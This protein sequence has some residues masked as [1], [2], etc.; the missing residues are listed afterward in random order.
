MKLLT[1]KYKYATKYAT[2][3]LLGVLCAYS[4]CA[5]DNIQR[6]NPN[7][8]QPD[9]E[10]PDSSQYEPNPTDTDQDKQDNQEHQGTPDNQWEQPDE[11]HNENP[12]NQWEQPDQDHNE[13]PNDQDNQWEQPDE[14]HQ[15][16][17]DEQNDEGKCDPGYVWV[18]YNID[19]WLSTSIEYGINDGK[20]YNNQ[21]APC[22]SVNWAI[23]YMY[24][25]NY[26]CPGG[27]ISD[28]KHKS[29]QRQVEKCPDYTY[30]NSDLS[31]C[32]CTYGVPP[33][34]KTCADLVN[35]TKKPLIISPKINIIRDHRKVNR[36]NLLKTKIRGHK[37]R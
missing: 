30:V 19:P 22:I 10:R 21:C 20:D 18:D 27:Y 32:D 35:G 37:T 15:E 3:L 9:N 26:Y 4:V 25:T 7:G 31:G 34:G 28:L 14:N 17:P 8:R 1:R 16:K 2:N 5:C 24:D 11:N 12:D 13:T 36:Q 6:I 33:P 23:K 29:I